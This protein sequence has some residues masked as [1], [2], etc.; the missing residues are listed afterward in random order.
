MY[1]CLSYPAEFVAR[2][3]IICRRLNIDR[4]M[5]LFLFQNL[6]SAYDMYFIS[7]CTLRRK[8]YTA[9]NDTDNII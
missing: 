4:I 5:A 1:W 6:Y 8:W 9:K 3:R 2:V 7:K